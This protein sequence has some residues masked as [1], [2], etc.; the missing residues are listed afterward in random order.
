MLLICCFLFNFV[1]EFSSCKKELFLTFSSLLCFTVEKNIAWSR[2]LCIIWMQRRWKQLL[3]LF[4]V[5][6]Q[7]WLL[8]YYQRLLLFFPFLNLLLLLIIERY[9]SFLFS[10]FS[11]SIFRAAIVYHLRMNYVG[12]YKLST[13]HD[14]VK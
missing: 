11:F 1:G 3:L 4:C 10:I 6:I 7:R 13:D 9:F 8:I 5:Y 2:N 14:F 12:V